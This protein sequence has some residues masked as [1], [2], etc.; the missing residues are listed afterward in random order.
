METPWDLVLEISR[1]PFEIEQI[2]ERL[3]CAFPRLEETN[4]L[5]IECFTVTRRD[6]KLYLLMLQMTGE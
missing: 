4:N 1:E 5:L 6:L 2:C 3:K